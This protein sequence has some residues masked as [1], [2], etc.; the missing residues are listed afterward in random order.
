[1]KHV[2]TNGKKMMY[3]LAQGSLLN[4]KHGTSP[5]YDLCVLCYNLII[6]CHLISCIGKGSIIR[7]VLL[8]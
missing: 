8:W 1:M 5:I 4:V 2:L 7:E 3:H 6:E